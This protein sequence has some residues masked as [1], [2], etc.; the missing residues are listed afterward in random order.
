MEDYCVQ[1]VEICGAVYHRYEHIIDDQSGALAYFSNI[2]SNS[3]VM[4]FMTMASS[5]T[6]IALAVFWDQLR[7]SWQSWMQSLKW[8]FRRKSINT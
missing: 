8:R 4:T 5:L 3:F 1:D 6:L 2:N 7:S